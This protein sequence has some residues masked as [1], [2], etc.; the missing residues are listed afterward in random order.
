MANK[1]E[2]NSF[3][4]N[5]AIAPGD[6]IRE[7]MEFL[8]MNQK[9]LAARLDIT[10]KH[11]SNIIN[12]KS[13]ITYDTALKLETVIG[14]SAQFWMNLE[15]NYQLAIS[16][17]EKMKNLE[18]DLSVLK[19]IP[20]LEMSKLGWLKKTSIRKERVF[21][22][23]K[24]FGV[25]NLTSV[26]PS[27]NVAF[28]QQKEIKE[29]SNLGVLAWL[30]KAEIEALKFDV[31]KFNKKKLKSII[32]QLREMTVE[33]LNE[34]FLEIQKLFSESG[35]V[36]LLIPYVAKTYICGATIWRDDKAIIALSGMGKRADNFWFTLFHELAHLIEHSKKSVHVSF[37]NT[38]DEA[39][40]EAR[41]YLISQK[42]YNYFIDNHNFKN[43]KE[44][45]Q[46]SKELKIAPFVLVGRLQH[47]GYIK[48]AQFRELLPK[49]DISK[50]I[51]S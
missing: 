13:P 28:R 44:I 47:D 21:N 46:Y 17:I 43:K 33:K 42:A 8:G 39:D 26:Q 7:N 20:Y 49:F 27:Y 16:R 48:Y 12:A 45:I 41:N 29:I 6:T 3:F 40:S 9:E 19:K 36:L 2:N 5:V 32:P 15:T 35:V 51:E 11:L 34:S 4:P 22:C 10:T 30:R 38:E 14:P 31:G 25:A 50:I 23:R 1:V 24:F 37:E 18:N